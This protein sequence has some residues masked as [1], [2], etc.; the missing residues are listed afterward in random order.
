MARQKGIKPV[1]QNRKAR[2]EYFVEEAFECGIALHGTEVK[3]MRQGRVNL[4]ESFAAVKDGEMIV[5]GMHISPYEQGNIFNTDPLRPKKL[6][7]HKAEI[8]RLAGLVQRQGYTLVPLSV[9]LKDGRMKM[10]L[11]LCRGKKLHDKRDDMAQ[12]DAK[13]DIDRALKNNGRGE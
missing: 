2:H 10:E 12:R 5:S 1:A 6:L 11:G 7:M 4:Q 9:Y 3:S 13:R 8:R